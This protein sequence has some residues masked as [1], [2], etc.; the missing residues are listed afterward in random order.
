[1]SDVLRVAIEGLHRSGNRFEDSAATAGEA[2]S[3]LHADVGGRG[4]EVWGHDEP[5]SAFGPG[6][7]ALR[8]QTMANLTEVHQALV[9]AAAMVHRS[10]EMIQSQDQDIAGSFGGG[11]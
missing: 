11:A 2:M 5:G 3:G 10:A 7:E 1:M 9:D 4:S 8:E 6:Y